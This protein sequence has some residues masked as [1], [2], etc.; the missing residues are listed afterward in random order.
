LPFKHIPVNPHR[1]DCQIAKP[2]FGR[3]HRGLSDGQDFPLPAFVADQH[4]G[5]FTR[6]LVHLRRQP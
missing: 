6:F 1:P 5:H 2:R 4:H 3:C